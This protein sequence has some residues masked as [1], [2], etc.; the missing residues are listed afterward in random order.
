MVGLMWDSVILCIVLRLTSD[1][2]TA[3]ILCEGEILF[4][5]KGP[6]FD[7]TVYEYFNDLLA[8]L[9]PGGSISVFLLESDPD[10]PD[11]DGDGALDFED[12]RPRRTNPDI[13]YIVYG[14][15]WYNEANYW[16]NKYQRE[17]GVEIYGFDDWETFKSIWDSFG[18]ADGKYAY[19]IR[20]VVLLYHGAI[21][22]LIVGD[23]FVGIDFRDDYYAHISELSDK[24]ID[25]LD[26]KICESGLLSAVDIYPNTYVPGS[27][28]YAYGYNIA[29]QFLISFNNINVVRA[30]NG[31][32]NVHNNVF[33]FYERCIVSS[34]EYENWC[35]RFSRCGNAYEFSRDMNIEITGIYVYYE[36]PL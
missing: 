28:D 15:E 14:A 35:Y 29:L 24:R 1:G 32:Y 3:Y 6:T 20:R 5:S 25:V 19:T 21:G 27:Q 16:Q 2:S 9:E 17:C 23:T 18:F 26:L 12:A 8:G 31:T 10:N 22:A 36:P 7:E 13:V 11:Y 34:N 30:W 33:G 4:I